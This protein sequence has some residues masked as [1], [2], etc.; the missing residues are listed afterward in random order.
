MDW[1]SAAR[2]ESPK[3]ARLTVRRRGPRTREW[4]VANRAQRGTGQRAAT[5]RRVL[6]DAVR[7]DA[8]RRPPEQ[9]DAS[10][11]AEW[12]GRVKSEDR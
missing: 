8:G 5:H 6:E 10:R 4:A 11:V 7:E 3:L 9:E 12:E 1:A 2:A